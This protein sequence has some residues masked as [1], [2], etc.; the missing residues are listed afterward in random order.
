MTATLHKEI[1]ISK[2]Y[3]SLLYK[4]L[5]FFLFGDYVARFREKNAKIMK[6]TFFLFA[7]LLL[8]IFFACK[9]DNPKPT[10]PTQGVVSGLVLQLNS[11]TPVPNAT[12]NVYSSVWSGGLGG[13]EISRIVATTTTN[14][15]GE[16][17][18]TYDTNSSTEHFVKA[19]ANNY[20][21]DN[22]T[23]WTIESNKY[24]RNI[25]ITPYAW[26]KLRVFNDLTIGTT[27]FISLSGPWSSTE[28]FNK[29]GKC[30][31]VFTKKVPGNTK[32]SIGIFF[33]KDSKVYLD[34]RDSI[35]CKGL[36]T[37]QHTIIY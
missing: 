5:L 12:V 32:I 2:P 1:L 7:A 35:F 19:Y 3:F 11:T 29:S 34:R 24:V 21:T 36:D 26:V 10:T 8:S 33:L 31:T 37:I 30:D 6:K 15:K 9:K 17:T 13:S 22:N 18:F 25:I 16:Y 23:R 20:Y 14:D 27:N 28:E 4:S